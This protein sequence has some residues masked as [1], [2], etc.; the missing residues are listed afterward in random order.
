MNVFCRD[1]SILDGR[2]VS[3]VLLCVRSVSLFVAERDFASP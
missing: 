1:R 3:G 2:R